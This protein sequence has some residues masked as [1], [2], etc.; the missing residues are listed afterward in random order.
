MLATPENIGFFDVVVKLNLKVLVPLVSVE[1]QE[2]YGMTHVC[3]H[4]PAATFIHSCVYNTDYFDFV[5][6]CAVWC[7]WCGMC[8]ASVRCTRT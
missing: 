2:D 8:C 3:K 7:V 1:I 5:V 4:S 6:V